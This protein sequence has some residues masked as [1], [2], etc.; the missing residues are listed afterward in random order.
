MAKFS[1]IH[2]RRAGRALRTLIPRILFCDRGSASVEFSLLAIPLF[3]P[4]FIFMSQFSHVSDAQDSMRTLARESAR[5][6]VT[7][8]NDETAFFVANQVVMQGARLLGYE[9]DSNETRIEMKITCNSQPCIAPDNRV[10]LQL[11]MNSPGKNRIEVAVVEYV[12]PWA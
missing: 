8:K 1:P 7:S 2:P 4:L 3:I 9:P 5:A 11:S 6:F 10:L 12:S